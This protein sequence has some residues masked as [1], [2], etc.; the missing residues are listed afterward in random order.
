MLLA[1]YGTVSYDPNLHSFYPWAH[2]SNLTFSRSTVQAD[3]LTASDAVWSSV[4]QTDKLLDENL[5][6]LEGEDDDEM[7]DGDDDATATLNTN[8]GVATGVPAAGEFMPSRFLHSGDAVEFLT[9]HGWVV[10]NE[11]EAGTNDQLCLIRPGGSAVSPVNGI[12]YPPTTDRVNDKDWNFTFHWRH[13]ES[14]K[15]SAAGAH[16]MDVV[17]E[18]LDECKIN[19]EEGALISRHD[20]FAVLTCVSH[21]PVG[22]NGSINEVSPVTKRG[23]GGSWRTVS[24]GRQR[25][26][27]APPSN[28]DGQPAKKAKTGT[29]GL[30]H[31]IHEPKPD[32]VPDM[33]SDHTLSC[34]LAAGNNGSKGNG[35]GRATKKARKK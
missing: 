14:D 10:H 35:Q 4:S 34:T 12:M 27:R 13:I 17:A 30:D 9:K 20:S 18:F 22:E 28:T 31:Q 16:V 32:T 25:R 11:G 29:Y 1:A 3:S 15:A 2:D 8:G 33:H 23:E 19:F 5:A 6:S 21:D 24:A 26:S 7:H